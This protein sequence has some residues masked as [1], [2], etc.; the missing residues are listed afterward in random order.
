MFWT[1]SCSRTQVPSIYQDK[2]S[3]QPCRKFYVVPAIDIWGSIRHDASGYA[4]TRPWN[5]T[6]A[7]TW[8]RLGEPTGSG[9]APVF[10]FYL[11]RRTEVPGHEV[12]MK[13]LPDLRILQPTFRFHL[14]R[15]MSWPAER[16]SA[17][18]NK[19]GPWSEVSSLLCFGVPSDNPRG[20]WRQTAGL[21]TTWR[22]LD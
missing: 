18:R 7:A 15:K 9:L 6:A 11:W 20:G 21:W 16:M 19:S 3:N 5:Y 13:M 1:T 8:W 4:I 2:P 12:H 14:R 10:T 22:F 17:S